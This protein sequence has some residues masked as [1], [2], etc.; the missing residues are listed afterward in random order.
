MSDEEL[1][2]IEARIRDGIHV[3]YR[4]TAEPALDALLAEVKRLR[5]PPT[6]ESVM[7]TLPDFARA[8][9]DAVAAELA[10]SPLLS[11]IQVSNDGEN[12]L[13]L[14][15]AGTDPTAYRYIRAVRDPRDNG[16]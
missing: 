9:R 12:W 8:V 1:E 11:A 10:K 13:A 15:S 2:K 3:D 6:A 4:D 14:S 7:R 16:C 5:A